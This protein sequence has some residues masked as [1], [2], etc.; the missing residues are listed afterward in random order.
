MRRFT[1][2]KRKT[3]KRIAGIDV[4][5]SILSGRNLFSLSAVLIDTGLNLACY[6]CSVSGESNTAFAASLYMY[7]FVHGPPGL[8]GTPQMRF[9]R[10]KQSWRPRSRETYGDLSRF[11]DADVVTA[12]DRN[13]RNLILKK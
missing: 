10:C 8:Y 1:R 11:A 13:G 5:R 2:K 12:I 4:R 6:T 3:G 9:N 7:M